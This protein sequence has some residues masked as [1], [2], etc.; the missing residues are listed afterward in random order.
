[1][2]LFE[3]KNLTFTYPLSSAPALK[4]IDITVESGEA[5]LLM[6]KSGS[7]KST[8]LRLLKKEIAPV[9]EL[10]G[11]IKINCGSIGYVGQNP[12]TSFVA[13]SVRGELAF[14]LENK[15]LSDSQ[16]TVKIGETASFFNIGR[17]LD[18]QLCDLSG[19]EKASVAIAAVMIADC[20]A[21]ILDEP[22]A[23]L[24]PKSAL[25]VAA[26][27]KRINEELGVTVITA[28]HSSQELIDFCD[29]IFILDGGR[30]VSSQTPESTAKS[31]EFLPFL[32]ISACLF[33]ERPLTVKAAAAY[34][35]RL[36]EKA[37]AEDIDLKEKNQKKAVELKS[38]TFAYGK[39]ERDILERLS[40]T[41]YSGKI[42]AVI[43]ANGSGKTTLLKVICGVKKAYSGKAKVNGK[44]AYMP[45]NVKYLFTK[46][47]VGEEISAKTAQRL[48]IADCVNQHPY[49]L[50]GGQAQK[51]AFGILL[52]QDADIFALDEPS[53]A[54]DEFSKQML[55]DFL[56]ELCK[57]GKTVI[58]VSHDLDFV[59]EIS[60]CVSFLTD[61][62]ISRA[63][64][65][66]QVLADLN[67]YTTQVRR[68]T[69]KALEN[70]VGICDLEL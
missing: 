30:I 5:I 38:I 19:G 14:A 40:F 68:I 53:K 61:G 7:G 64:S 37:A 27:L 46:E 26:M 44:V 24:D 12:E 50:S 57:S 56:R 9:G 28:T 54:F 10:Q 6:G 42:N 35:E 62:I 43:G 36:K 1:M 55:A 2:A 33:D 47:T 70:A 52:E 66:R 59:G 25:D 21:L 11:E 23:Q 31:A 4:N 39:N 69:K 34:A 15:G 17:L 8:L 49:D 60:D 48:G 20:D 65:R 67:F 13:Q 63:G 51:L 22:L 58:L 45:Q 41:A 3:A 32:P 29:R 18:K 16:I